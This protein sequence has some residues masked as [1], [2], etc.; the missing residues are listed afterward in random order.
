MEISRTSF[1]IMAILITIVF[2]IIAPVWAYSDVAGTWYSKGIT[3]TDFGNYSGAIESFEKAIALEPDY[4]EAWN[5]KADAL[6][7]AK[8]YQDALIASDQVLMINPHYG[9]GWINRGYILYNLGRYDEELNAYDRAIDIDPQNADAWFNR[10]YA[11]AAVRRYDEAIRAFDRVAELDPNYPNLLA[12]RR[13]AETNRDEA[14]PFLVKYA[15]W[16]GI[17]LL[18]VG[19]IGILMYR[20]KTR[21]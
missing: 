9:K 19:G 20:R 15:P 21:K 6:N 13:I 8:K 1:I 18:I 5:G 10:G 17:S 4:F 2:S 12:N 14:T 11:L 7:R 16:I 3:E